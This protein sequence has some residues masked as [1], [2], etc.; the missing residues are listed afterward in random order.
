MGPSRQALIAGAA[1]GSAFRLVLPREA[2]RGRDGSRA[3]TGAGASLD[4]LDFREYHPGD[5]LR[6]LDWSVYARTDREV[7]RLYREEVL[8]RLDLVLDVS[9]S[10][11]LP[12][13]GK[14]GAALAL[15][16]ALAAAATNAGCVASLWTVGADVRRL[17][18]SDPRLWDPPCFDSPLPPVAGFG[19]ER[20]SFPRNGIRVL[21]SDLLFPEEPAAL[22]RPLSDGAAATYVL[23]VLAPDE[24]EPRDIGPRRLLD[25]ESGDMLDAVIDEAALAAYRAAFAAHRDRWTESCRAHGAA[26]P[27][28]PIAAAWDMGVG[29]DVLRSLVAP[30]LRLGLVESL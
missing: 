12:G 15:C 26:F 20:P 28:D 13:T 14:A 17:E 5:D 24:I 18:G 21:V 10:M 11:D 6:R 16:G 30:L 4:F 29:E 9:R 25:V 19:R 1:L 3:G 2:M 27:T 23:Q 22:L 8:P 7:V